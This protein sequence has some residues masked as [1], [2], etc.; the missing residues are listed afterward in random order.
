MLPAV[1]SEIAI[2]EFPKTIPW[3]HTYQVGVTGA[4]RT[5]ALE[6]E[7]ESWCIVMQ[8]HEVFVKLCL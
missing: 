5:R 1:Y 8:L 3:T 4:E 6:M 7:E 2:A